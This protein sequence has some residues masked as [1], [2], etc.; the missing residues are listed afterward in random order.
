M[1]RVHARGDERADTSREAAVDS[2]SQVLSL[3][4]SGQLQNA[5]LNA[6][7]K[8]PTLRT[9]SL[10]NLSANFLCL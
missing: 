5:A 9:D 8:S 6:T 4:L 3:V 7:R 2:L 10:Y 1:L